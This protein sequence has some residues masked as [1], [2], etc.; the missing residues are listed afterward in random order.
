MVLSR[1]LIND[2]I[3]TWPEMLLQR[4]G[5]NSMILYGYYGGALYA[6]LLD[7]FGI[8][9]RH[10]ATRNTDMGLLLMEALDIELV[11]LDEID[12]EKYGYSAISARVRG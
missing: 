4:S 8:E 11:S 3:Q 10:T 12:L 6:M 5:V 9:F 1:D 7:D 2:V